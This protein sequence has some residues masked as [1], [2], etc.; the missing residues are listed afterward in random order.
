MGKRALVTGAL[1][2]SGTYQV[3]RLLELGYE[4][5]ATDLQPLDREKLMTKERVFRNDLTMENVD[6]PNVTFVAA[7]L[8]DKE[9]LHALW[10]GGEEYDMV[11][12]PASLYDYF[13]PLHLLLQINV[14][15][16][17]NLLEV[18][19]ERQAGSLPRFIHWSTAGVYGEPEYEVVRDQRGR[20]V[21]LPAD[22]TAPY[23]PP[24]WYSTSKMFQEVVVHDFW[25]NHGVPATILRPIVIAGP[26]QLY[27]AFH[28]FYLAHKMGVVPVPVIKPSV[29]QTHINLCHV[30]DL[31]DAA[32]FCA[33]HEETVGEAYNVGSEST[34]QWE[35]LDYLASISDAHTIIIPMWFRVYG[36]IAGIMRWW[37]RRETAKA[38]K[39]GLR[40]VIDLAMAEYVTHDYF[41]SNEK[42]RALGFEYRFPTVFDVT[43]DSVRWYVDHGWFD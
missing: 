5:T 6:D 1:G 25:K 8:T 41:F 37:C 2:H 15:G 39:W 22:E 40:P 32:I 31:A 3:K 21:K 26:H 28:L 27:G 34:T 38:R 42:L 36:A 33:E 11:F 9:S 13:A 43:R 20:K 12:H 23:R 17:R 30:E 16:T 7:D 14:V 19:C 18:V 29:K 10:A 35:F 24:N 4:V